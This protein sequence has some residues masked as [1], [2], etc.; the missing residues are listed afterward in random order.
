[1]V[2]VV[3]LREMGVNYEGKKK[4]FFFNLRLTIWVLYETIKWHLNWRPVIWVSR[5]RKGEWERQG[6][7]LNQMITSA[8]VRGGLGGVIALFNLSLLCS[9]KRNKQNPSYSCSQCCRWLQMFPELWLLL[10]FWPLKKCRISYNI[11]LLVGRSSNLWLEM[12]LITE[13]S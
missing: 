9:C 3:E 8:F 11:G 6:W 13:A 4:I 5:S 1:M 12:F 10:E 7:V 2:A